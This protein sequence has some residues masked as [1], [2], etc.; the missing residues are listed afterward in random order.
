MFGHLLHEARFYVAW[1]TSNLFVT[2][3]PY[4]DLPLQSVAMNHACSIGTLEMRDF[5]VLAGS[6]RFVNR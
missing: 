6:C 5:Y 1:F 4:G 2:M 3:K